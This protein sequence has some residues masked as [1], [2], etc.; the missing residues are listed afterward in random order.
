MTH[1]ELRYFVAFFNTGP[2][3]RA[4]VTWQVTLE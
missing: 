3:G 1:N 2:I 4:A